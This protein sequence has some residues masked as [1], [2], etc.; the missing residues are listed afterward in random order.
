MLTLIM[1]RHAFLQREGIRS[2]RDRSACSFCSK[3]QKYLWWRW[4]A[5]QRF[6]RWV[7]EH[8]AEIR[9]QALRAS[10]HAELVALEPSVL[11][12][13]V[14]LTFEYTCG[15]ASGQ[16][17]VTACTWSACQYI[18]AQLA[19]STLMPLKSFAIET[20]HSGDKRVTGLTLSRGRGIRVTA[21]CVLPAQVLRDELK[22][23]P[24]ALDKYFRLLSSSEAAA[25]S[26]G[27]CINIANS[28]AG[29][30]IATGQDIACVHE[31]SVGIFHLE[32]QAD[33]SIYAS[34]TLPCLVVGT[35]GG[36]TG[37]PQQ[38]ECLRM[39]GCAGAGKVMRFAEC[40]TAY[41][42]GLE[43]STMSALASD[44]FAQAHERMGR[45]R[46]Q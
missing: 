36:G 28:I 3:K 44:Q 6:V 12:R 5:A 17:M 38:N 9:E 45:N 33:S 26:V 14:H 11:G 13:T 10:R 16:N 40:I 31:S 35:V 8:T 39:F 18:R 19:Q 21:E 29:V 23:E 2:R 1:K 20:G 43:L 27:C 34:I 7:E 22:V 32:L 42:M 15:D 46:P 30:F 37:V 24:A 4:A 41:C 25:G